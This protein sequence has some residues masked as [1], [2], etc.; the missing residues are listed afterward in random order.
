MGKF[1]KAM[2][3]LGNGLV[4]VAEVASQSMTPE[5]W[6]DEA[7]KAARRGDLSLARS[8]AERGIE[9]GR[10]QFLRTY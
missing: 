8:Y 6:Y 7:S 9:V 3:A 2:K 10:R 1:K 4:V 5:Y